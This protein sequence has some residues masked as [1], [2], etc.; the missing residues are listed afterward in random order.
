MVDLYSDCIINEKVDIW[1]CGCFLYKVYYFHYYLV[2]V[3]IIFI[4]KGI[5]LGH[6]MKVQQYQL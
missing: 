2:N 1:A 3:K 5:F 4:L 6:L